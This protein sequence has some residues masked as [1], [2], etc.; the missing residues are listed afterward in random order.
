MPYLAAAC[1]FCLLTYAGYSH[2]RFI[3][4]DE[5]LELSIIRLDNLPQIWSALNDGV[6]VDPPLLDSAMH[7][8][9]RALGDSLFLARMPSVL[10]F[11][12]MCL[13]LSLIVWR[14]APPAYAA[15]TFFMPFAT[16]MRGLASLAR[17]YAPMLGFSALALLCWDNLQHT[18]GRRRSIWRVAFAISL[19]LA[20]STHFYSVLI[21]L[22]LGLGELAK[23]IL[24]KRLD[25]PT[26][27]CMAPALV[28][29]ALGCP[30]LLSASH[31]FGH[32]YAYKADAQTLYD[33]FGNLIISLP[34]AGIVLL[35]LFATAL[36]M[37]ARA[38][39]SPQL[40]AT[41]QRRAMLVVCGGFLLL[42]ICGYVGGVLVTG[43]FP[44]QYFVLAG[45]GLVLALALLPAASGGSRAPVGLCLFVAMTG[46]GLIVGARGMSGF[47]RTE[48]P[49]P[50][51]AAIR[52]LIPDPGPHPDIVVSAP[53]QFLPFYEATKADPENNLLY[54]F[55]PA[56]E[57]AEYGNDTADTASSILVGRTPARLRAFD[58]YVATHRQFFILTMGE[59]RAAQE[60]QFK[61]LMKNLGAR[62]TWLGKL[63]GFDL[64]QVDLP[65]LTAAVP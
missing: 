53:M 44:P 24:R 30:I 36:P 57:L 63:G 47:L 12:L 20:L 13:C 28:A 4:A 21:L 31:I 29:Y 64:Y 5:C 40:P 54:L 65:E 59:V 14:Y 22:P 61:Y 3:V 45:L 42:P 26:V 2:V 1:L 37:A 60:W 19:A 46:H 6:Q 62:L 56:K 32:H 7:F 9:F 34:W 58:P 33:F 48:R 27:L 17:P 16:S 51:L 10:C 41:P 18:A 38:Q 15:A 43:T 25:W 11:C 55:D 52:R 35:L 49:Y 39:V 23:W 8:G 50:S